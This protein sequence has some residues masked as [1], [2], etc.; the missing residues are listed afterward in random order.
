M[1]IPYIMENMEHRSHGW[2]HQPEAMKLEFPKHMESFRVP[3]LRHI[4]FLAQPGGFLTNCPTR[5][6]KKVAGKITPDWLILN[7]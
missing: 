4:G 7:Y 5:Q 6:P 3:N 2:N 1:I